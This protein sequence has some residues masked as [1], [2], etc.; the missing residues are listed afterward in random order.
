M[1]SRVDIFNMALGHIGVSSTVADELERSPERVI[2]T[3]FWDTCRDALFSYKDMEWKF[4]ATTV[5]LADLGSPPDGWGFRYRYPNDC[6]NAHAILG[7]SSFGRAQDEALR[8]KFD[9]QF[10]ADGRVILCD[11]P[12]AVLRY[13]KRVEE[14]ERWPSS[15]VE[16]MAFRLASMIAMPLKNDPGLRDNLLQVAEQFAQIAM[17]SSLNEGQPD[18]PIP[19]VYEMAINE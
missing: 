9:V 11:M 16:A 5:V 6:I 14:A 18:G 19:S 2:C 8:P 7:A 13:T 12:E 17:A 10:E 3:R 15:F 1:S 4:A